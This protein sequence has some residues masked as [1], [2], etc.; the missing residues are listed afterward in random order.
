MADARR[1]LG[2]A[3]AVGGRR[4]AEVRPGYPDDAVEWLLASTAAGG[5][6]ADVGAGTGKLTATLAARGLDVVAVDPSDDM[7]A[8]LRRQLPGVRTVLGT[9]EHTTL[10]DA[11]VDAAVYA[12]SWHWVDPDDGA[13]ELA[14]IVRPG[15]VAAMVWNFLDTDVEWVADFSAIMHSTKGAETIGPEG[16][17]PRLPPEAFTPV[18]EAQFSFVHHLRPDAL[19]ALVTTR[20]YYLA[21]DEAEQRFVY[22][23]ARAFV[24]STFRT[25]DVDGS[26]PGEPI[27]VP[28]RTYCYRSRRRSSA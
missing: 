28:Y 2:R 22:D 8:Q 16:R 26:G 11:S 6:V 18:E 1:R 24:D 9:G 3:F 23:R 5:R 27:G 13:A 4:F 20:S 7:L 19:A 12:Q 14:R 21:A 15:G 10:L 25:F 17:R